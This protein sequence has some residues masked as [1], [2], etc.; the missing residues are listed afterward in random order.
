VNE[1]ETCGTCRKYDPDEGTCNHRVAGDILMWLPASFMRVEMDED[2]GYGCQM[3]KP[4]LAGISRS[5]VAP[6]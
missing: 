3:Y 2:D 5:P 4:I 1:D 6:L